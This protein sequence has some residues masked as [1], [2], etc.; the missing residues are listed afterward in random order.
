MTDQQFL[1]QNSIPDI[2]TMLFLLKK[3]DIEADICLPMQ[4]LS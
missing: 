3:H 4:D 1:E 2:L